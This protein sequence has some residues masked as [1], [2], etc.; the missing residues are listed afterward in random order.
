MTELLAWVAAPAILLILLL[1]LGLLADRLAGTRLAPAL[2]APLGLVAMIVLATP[3]YRLHASAAV[4][5]PVVVVASAAGYVL[6]RA[7]LRERLR[8]GPWA[9]SALA[10]YLLY[11]AP[12]MLSGHATWSGY[13]FVNDTAANF[14]LADLLVHHG[15]TAPGA[16]SGTAQTATYLATSGYPIGSYSVLA[17]LA[18]LTGAPIHAVFQPLLSAFAALAAMS[19]TEV[20]RRAGLR[21]AAAAMAAAIALGGVLLYRYTLHGAIKEI[22][23][24]ALLATSAALAAVALERRLDVRSVA[25]VAVGCL[26]TV[27]VF[28]AAAGAYALALGVALLAAALLSPNRPSGRH[29]ARLAAVAAGAALVV[30]LPSLGSTLDFADVVRDVFRSDGGVSTGYFGQLLRP[31]PVTETAGIWLG[32]DY[33]VE[34]EAG[35][36]GLNAALVTVA[37]ALAA[38]GVGVCAARRRF[39]PLILLAATLLPALALAHFVSPYADGKLFVALTP[40]V[41]LVAAIGALTLVQSPRAAVRAAGVAAALL[42]AGGVLASDLYGFRETPLAP[43][44]RVA[45]LEDAAD[46][47]PGN[48]LWLFNE[49]EEFGKYFMREQSIS[50]ASEAES[51]RPVELRRRQPLFGRWFDLD[52]Q[53]LAY[54]QGFEGVIMRRSPAASRPPASFRMIYRNRYYELW[55]RDPNVRV[56]EHLPLQG[57]HRATAVASCGAIR[58]LARR[59]RPGERLIA[60]SRPGIARVSPFVARRPR[61]WYPNPAARGT[62]VPAGP[63]TMRGGATVPGG[64]TRVWLRVSVGRPF[65]VRVDGRRVGSV[66]Q[67]NTPDQWLEA[68]TIDLAPGSHRVEVRREGASLRPGDSYRGELGPLALEPLRPHRLVS[69]APSAAGAGLCGRPWDWVE[70]VEDGPA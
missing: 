26:A 70:R 53:R 21:P 58:A 6:A 55:Q 52:L 8:P 17:T 68:G 43:T 65:E 25:L 19:L 62:V 15:A 22:A 49:W 63:G 66:Q 44:D 28:S 69:I 27:L 1:G 45:S 47:I 54:V 11:L 35:L 39:A 16:G 41:V 23:L 60:A 59:A 40:A 34:A 64:R 4:A 20:A 42:L 5:I 36:G 38:L 14:I 2:L 33:R 31:L 18:P 48:G 67:V 30:L 9:W 61:D 50:P 57:S 3:V 32:R 46:H 51:A 13:N 29:L 10:V 24:V 7:E 56:R 12:V 37:I